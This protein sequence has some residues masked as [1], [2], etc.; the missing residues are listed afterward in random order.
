MAY[1]PFDKSVPDASTESI[2]QI[3]TSTRE[4]FEAIRD[5]VVAGDMPGWEMSTSGGTAEQPAEIIY[6]RSTERVKIALTWGSSGGADGNVTDAIYSYSSNS[7]T[8]YD[9]MADTDFPL[10][11]QTITYDSSGNVTAT[12]WS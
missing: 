4:N 6:A 9:L 1:T 12:G 5:A 8:N 10:A 2:N 7:G 3:T 11:K